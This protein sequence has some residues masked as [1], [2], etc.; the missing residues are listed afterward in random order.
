MALGE[1]IMEHKTTSIR[2]KMMRYFLIVVMIM[3]ICLVTFY[4]ISMDNITRVTIESMENVLD[5]INLDTYNTLHE[6]QEMAYLVAKDKDIQLALR[7]ELPD[8]DKE[9][10]SQRIERNFQL[11]DMNRFTKNL[12]GIYVVGENGA[13]F[14]SINQSM[15]Q[16]DF[17]QEDWYL[18][19]RETEEP[20]WIC[21]GE[22]SFMVRDM[23]EYMVSII[24]PI[25]DR[26]SYRFLGVTVVDVLMENLAQIS[27][28]GMVF[29]GMLLLL[30]EEN[31]VLYSDHEGKLNDA[32]MEQL[33]QTLKDGEFK[34]DET[35]EI[36]L[37]GNGFLISQTSLDIAGWKIAGMVSDDTIYAQIS[38]IRSLMLVV[39]GICIC[40]S[41]MLA[42]SASKGISQPI[43]AIRSIMH[44]VESGDLE[45]HV[46]VKCNDEVGELANSFNHMVDKLNILV[47]EQEENQKKLRIA[48]LNALQAQINPHFLYNT[49][50][51]INWMAR[52]GQTD[53][54]SEMVNSLSV[55]FRISLSRGKTFITVNEELRHVENYIL[56]QKKRYEKY[57]DYEIDVPESIRGYKCLKM[58]LQPLV[59]NSIY[60]GIKEKGEKGLIRITAQEA[61]DVLVFSVTDTGQ[62]MTAEKLRELQEMMEK[63]IEYNAGAYGVINVQRRIQTY[64]GKSY[65]IHFHSVWGEGTEVK[66]VIPRKVMQEETDELESSDR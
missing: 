29:D 16:M 38:A 22:G 36:S 64:F 21:Q 51:S 66:V 60:H 45:T 43:L 2:W 63:G 35:T 11:S 27:Q 19:V 12:D 47:T 7:G 32:E 59:E 53:Q 61:Q 37:S 50:D 58:I 40:L 52:A 46:D 56:I 41:V 42:I 44:K 30:N 39:S 49:L 26:A 33:E 1:P 31:N 9:L 55:F 10:Y 48:E 6:A 20:V 28:E 54:V 24:V 18:Q 25:I 4:Q 15:Y 13:F 3:G 65:G 57:L 17:R 23:D 8:T 14:R 5:K 34:D 62:G